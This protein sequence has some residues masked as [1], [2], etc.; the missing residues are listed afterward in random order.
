MNAT[1]IIL[2]ILTVL[3]LI[4]C[5]VAFVF[6]YQHLWRHLFNGNYSQITD[7]NVQLE[8][9]RR[10][11]REVLKHGEKHE[12]FHI[13]KMNARMIVDR[14]QLNNHL[15]D[16]DAD[17]RGMLCEEAVALLP[18]LMNDHLN[19]SNTIVIETPANVCVPNDS[20]NQLR[21]VVSRWL[22]DKGYRYEER[23]PGV[24]RV[25]LVRVTAK[26]V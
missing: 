19:G 10:N 23:F 3:G 12:A 9:N 16:V 26:T 11:A 15:T 18:E 6:Q 4:F 13:Y 5:F 22:H 2:V 21:K 24:F 8:E 1:E 25:N 20:E 7:D 14:N 17:F